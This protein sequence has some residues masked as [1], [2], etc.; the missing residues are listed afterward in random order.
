[1]EEEKIF[2][3]SIEEWR[4]VAGYEGFYQVSNYGRIKVLP[5]LVSRG[6]CTITCPEK[7]LKPRVKNNQY[8]FVRLS[9]GH[10][11]TSKEKY[12]HRLVAEAFLPNR[13]G[14]P[15][16]DH[17]DGDRTNNLV[18]NLRWATRT[19]NVRNPNTLGKW[20]KKILITTKDGKY[21]KT[22]LSLTIASKELN[23]PLSTLSWAKNN[24]T[25]FRYIIKEL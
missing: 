11:K 20:R 2:D 3:M 22:F 9:N 7:I 6:F 25:N 4:D 16:I 15:E 19:E 1:M 24:P 23:I 12:V 5:H 18:T 14:K 8:L 13:K 21:S 17:I 10:K